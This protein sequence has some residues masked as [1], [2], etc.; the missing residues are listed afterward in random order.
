MHACT[1][2]SRAVCWWRSRA[3][4]ELLLNM[5]SAA[6]HVSSELIQELPQALHNCPDARSSQPLCKEPV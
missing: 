1:L 4:P 5:A 6:L 3:C 2:R